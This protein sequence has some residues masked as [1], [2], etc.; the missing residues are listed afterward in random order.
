[1]D[2]AAAL[3]QALAQALAADR[4]ILIEAR[5]AP[6]GSARRTGLLAAMAHAAEAAVGA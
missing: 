4:P 3:A 2:Q 5:V 6:G 1:M